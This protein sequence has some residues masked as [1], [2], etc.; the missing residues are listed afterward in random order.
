MAK[1]RQKGKIPRTE[2]PKI[3]AT[4][5]SGQTIAEIG[6]RYGCT[7]P[8]IRYIIKQ[9]GMLKSDRAGAASAIVEPQR[10]LHRE[11]HSM[12]EKGKRTRPS[13]PTAARTESGAVLRQELRLRLSG[14]IASFLVSFDEA[15]ARSS[16]KSLTDLLEATD[17][18]M[19]SA[20]RTRLEIERIMLEGASPRSE[21]NLGGRRARLPSA[22]N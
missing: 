20:A 4:Y 10:L 5:S 11:I 7:A 6:R 3:I 22:R 9:N 21:E 16:M 14:D 2:W 15:V 12:A 18:L 8:A 17:S 1:T 13:I 19:R